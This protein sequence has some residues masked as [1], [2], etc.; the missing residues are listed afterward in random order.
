MALPFQLKGKLSKGC[1]YIVVGWSSNPKR[2][3][4]LS[5]HRSAKQARQEYAKYSRMEGRLREMLPG[6]LGG[7]QRKY[8][9]YN[10]KSGKRLV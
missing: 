7:G 1:K 4:V 5:C 8:A 2:R 10:V 9:V 3:T 6:F